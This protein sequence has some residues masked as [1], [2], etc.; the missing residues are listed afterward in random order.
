MG[1]SESKKLESFNI[2]VIGRRCVGKSTLINSVFGKKLANEGNGK[3]CTIQIEPYTQEDSHL[4]LYDT[5]SFITS[6]PPKITDYKKKIFDLISA[7]SKTKDVNKFIHCIWYCIDTNIGQIFE[8]EKQ[9][10]SEF[11]NIPVIVVLTRSDNREKANMMMRKVENLQMK[12]NYIVPILARK[13]N[14]KTSYGVDNLINFSINSLPN[15]MRISYDTLEF[16]S[17]KKI[18]VITIGK[19]GVGKSTLI[20]AVFGKD[21]AKEGSGKPVTSD[22]DEYIDKDSIFSITDVPGFELNP[23]QQMKIQNKITEKIDQKFK[24]DENIHCIWYCIRFSSSRIEKSEIDFINTISTHVKKHQIPVIIVLTQCYFPDDRQEMFQSFENLNANVFKICP[25]ISKDNEYVMNDDE[26]T[27]IIKS[28]GIES[29]K[30]F[31]CQ[32]ANYKYNKFDITKYFGQ[33][34]EEQIKNLKKIN[35]V[36]IGEEK[37]GKNT[38][39]NTILEGEIV[40]KVVENHEE[41]DEY[42]Q[43]NKVFNFFDTPIVDNDII[44]Q[45]KLHEIIIQFIKDRLKTK[46]LNK[47]IHCVWYCIKCQSNT[48]NKSKIHFIKTLNDELK[49][50]KIPV[51]FVIT[52]CYN[53]DEKNKITQF[54][55]KNFEEIK[56]KQPI[57]AKKFIDE[58]PTSTIEPFGVEELKNLTHTA[59]SET[60][61]PENLENQVAKCYYDIMNGLNKINVITIGKTGVGKSTLINNFF[62]GHLAATGV[63]EPVTQNITALTIPDSR[64]T[65]YDTPGLELNKSQQVDVKE[66]ITKLIRDGYESKDLNKHIHCIWFCVNCESARFEESEKE[67]IQEL[68]EVTSRFQVPVLVVLTQA[69]NRRTAATMKAVIEAEKLKIIQVIPVV[70]EARKIGKSICKAYGL[71]VLT[72][73]MGNNLPEDLKITFNNVQIASLSYKRKCAWSTISAYIVS[74]ASIGASPIPFSDC[75]LLVGIEAAM[76]SSITAIYNVEVGHGFVSNFIGSVVGCFSAT[77]IGRTIVVNLIKCIPGVGSIIGAVVGGVTGSVLTGIFGGVYVLIIEAI[78]RREF[79]PKSISKEE[80]KERIEP[81]FKEI[82]AKFSIFKKVS[83]S[84]IESVIKEE[85]ESRSENEI[86]LGK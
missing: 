71:D 81:I 56:Y 42:E 21:Y 59:I 77:V 72:E 54:I 84:E 75:F 1:N 14:I 48:M 35:I 10:I 31:T 32:A 16:V 13:T 8:P 9:L 27:E 17:N 49:A 58:D 51:I 63:G 46:E 11:K 7:Q 70:A 50:Y 41:I 4:N 12:V 39:I 20:N 45:V 29:L 37:S 24:N 78:L 86:E 38:L 2:L 19:T 18:N 36:L 34:I 73:I 47:T 60:I 64:L 52:Q 62:R 67:F 28:F 30:K 83:E 69:Y 66:R 22:I 23:D 43:D 79:D 25:V 65:I 40:K 76:I 44:S 80:L 68:T 53:G 3:P 6:S 5:P 15:N 74:S 55:D 33:N 85:I 61:L 26:Q 57:V 82:M